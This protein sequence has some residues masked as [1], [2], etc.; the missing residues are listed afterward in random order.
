MQIPI[1][2]DLS[3]PIVIGAVGNDEFDF[4]VR[5]QMFEVLPP[6]LGRFARTW[7]FNIKNYRSIFMDRSNVDRSGC[8]DEDLQPFLTTPLDQ[9]E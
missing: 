2:D 8:F 5:L 4:V 1:L 3:R 6:V 7:T 9:I